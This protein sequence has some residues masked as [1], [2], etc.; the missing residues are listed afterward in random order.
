VKYYTLCC[1]D[2]PF[3]RLPGKAAGGGRP[4]VVELAE[5]DDASEVVGVVGGEAFELFADGHGSVGMAGRGWAE[6]GAVE[7]GFVGCGGAGLLVV[8]EEALAELLPAF[9]GEVLLS[10]EAEGR[11]L[12]AGSLDAGDP[13]EGDLLPEGDMPELGV[14]GV[15]RA[16][17][18]LVGEI[19]TE[20]FE[21]V[22]GRRGGTVTDEGA[23]KLITR[24]LRFDGHGVD[25][26]GGRTGRPGSRASRQSST[27]KIGLLVSL[28]QMELKYSQSQQ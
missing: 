13:V 2:T 19:G 14:D 8:A 12:G 9:A 10:W 25:G 1:V 6:D 15:G 21:D 7:T 11:V 27:T 22:G 3:C 18:F 24:L 20:A 26:R 5:E 16:G 4:G 28:R 17:S 23:L